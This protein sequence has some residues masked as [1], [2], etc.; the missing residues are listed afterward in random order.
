MSFSGIDLVEAEGDDAARRLVQLGGKLGAGR[1]GADDRDVELARADRLGLRIGAHAGVDQAAVEALGLLGR[2]EHDGVLVDAGRAEVVADAADGDD[3][4]I[5]AE[6]AH[7][8]DLPAI[9]VVGGGEEYELLLAVDPGHLAVAELEPV[10]VALRLVFELVL[11]RIHAAGRDLVQQR[12]PDMRARA[13]DERD[14]RLLLAAELVA[15]T[16][17][18]LQ[19]AGA[20][21]DDDDVRQ[22]AVIADGHYPRRRGGGRHLSHRKRLMPMGNYGP[23]RL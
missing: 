17:R 18:Q 23:T 3:Q 22:V 15:E 21:A 16:R 19:A 14:L 7:R 12:L 5:V 1:A 20:A 9:L 11:R 10:P 8:R 2:I 4:R 13:L 6:R